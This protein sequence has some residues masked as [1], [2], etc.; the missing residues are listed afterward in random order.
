MGMTS[1]FP[2]NEIPTMGA[3]QPI[4]R[5]SLATEVAERLSS[6][7]IS[8]EHAENSL[9][10]TEKELCERLGVSRTVVREAIKLLESRGLVR[11][12]RGRG[13]LVCEASHRSVTE[14]MRVL[15]QRKTA[16]LEHLIEVRLVVEVAMASLAAARRTDSNLAILERCL[17]VMREHPAQPEGYVDADVEFH[18]EIARATGNPVFPIVLGPIADLL[19]DSRVASFS[20]AKMVKLRAEQHQKI[21]EAIRR[22]DGD[23]AADAM[24][25]HLGDTMKDLCRRRQAGLRPRA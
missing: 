7:I 14:S 3:L 22:G 15:I 5:R 8:G 12:E 20:G 21:F 24:R 4:L 16:L 10:P 18:N 11:I 25:E 2:S 17:R 9:L 23:A 13:T 1:Y 6:G 19:H